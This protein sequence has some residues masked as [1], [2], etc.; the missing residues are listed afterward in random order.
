M[1]TKVG[2]LFETD[3]GRE[4]LFEKTTVIYLGLDDDEGA[5]RKR[6]EFPAPGSLDFLWLC[7]VGLLCKIYI[8]AFL[9]WQLFKA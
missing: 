9:R 6:F 7:F 5:W 8:F 3:S 2:D 4:H 1:L